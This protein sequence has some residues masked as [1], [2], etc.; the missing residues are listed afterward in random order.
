MEF[1]ITII[2]IF[3]ILVTI[4]IKEF[5]KE[6]AKHFASKLIQ[7]WGDRNGNSIS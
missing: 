1:L 6:I 2:G 7:W 4:F 5:L 3:I